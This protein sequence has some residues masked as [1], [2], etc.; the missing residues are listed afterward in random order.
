MGTRTHSVFRR[1][2]QVFEDEK[3]KASM[4]IG[5]I[6]AG[7]TKMVCAIGETGRK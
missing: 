4:L 5:E 2:T 6:E 7:G 3:E 1:T